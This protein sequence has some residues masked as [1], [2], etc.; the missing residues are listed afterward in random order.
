[1][2]RKVF[3]KVFFG[4]DCSKEQQ[5]LND[6]SRAGYRLVSV[7]FGR[8]VFEDCTP[9]L[10]SYHIQSS[11]EVS[12]GSFIGTVGSKAYYLMSNYIPFATAAMC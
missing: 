8:Y 12:R 6:M 2:E 9:S 1:M 10:Y 11:R 5:W 3:R 4:N 7:R